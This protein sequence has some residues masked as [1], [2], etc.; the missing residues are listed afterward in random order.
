M[1]CT[2]EELRGDQNTR[3]IGLKGKVVDEIEVMA[4]GSSEEIDT[5]ETSWGHFP[6]KDK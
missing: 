6:S 2:Y 1:F 3:N 5:T 4:E